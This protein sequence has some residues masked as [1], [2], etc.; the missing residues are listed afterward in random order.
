VADAAPALPALELRWMQELTTEM[1]DEGPALT[2]LA[3]YLT[4]LPSRIERII[5]ELQA[6]DV[7]AALD[8]LVSLKV[9]S[10][11]AGAV[12]AAARCGAIESLVRGRRFGPALDAGA[13]LS[14]HVT[15][16]LDAAPVLL[17]E[18]RTALQ[19]AGT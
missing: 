9:T 1:D 13:G 10:S 18:A 2:F 6:Q 16:L 3:G 14:R 15:G 5:L 7:E 17:A 11:M 19:P 4:M 8:A 12:E